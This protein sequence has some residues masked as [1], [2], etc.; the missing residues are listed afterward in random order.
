MFYV[1]DHEREKSGG[2]YQ[3]LSGSTTKKIPSLFVS[4]QLGE[5]SPYNTITNIH[6]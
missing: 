6:K 1:E 4:L 2:G 5:K 3:D